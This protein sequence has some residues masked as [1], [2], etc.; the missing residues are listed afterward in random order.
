MFTVRWLQD[1]LD[2]LT[3]SWIQ[4]DSDTRREVTAATHSIDLA[5]QSDPRQESESRDENEFVRFFFPLGVSFEIDTE[6]ST[7]YILHVWQFR[8]RRVQS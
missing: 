3:T 7:V 6:K 1:A 8:H 2:D 4:A 5:L